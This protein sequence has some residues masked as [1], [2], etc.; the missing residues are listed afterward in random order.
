MI[1]K[2]ALFKKG[3]SFLVT[4]VMLVSSVIPS[5][6]FVTSA[7]DEPIVTE[8]ASQTINE[9]S[10]S[11]ARGAENKGTVEEPD[12][13]WTASNSG[14]AGTF[15]FQLNYDLSGQ[16]EIGVGKMQFV[17]PKHIIKNRD[18]AYAVIR[19]EHAAV[20]RIFRLKDLQ[21]AACDVLRTAPVTAH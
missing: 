18:G 7:E 2:K 3:L 8:T 13:V 20:F 11:F 15:V 14:S 6:S 10:I 21:G 5:L 17:V 1:R 4:A 12:Y 19:V 9:F 16:N